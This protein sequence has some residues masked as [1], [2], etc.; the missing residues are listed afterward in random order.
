MGFL[1]TSLAAYSL[2]RRREAALRR[3]F[4]QHLAPGVVAR[5]AGAPEALK[6]SGEKR[7]VTALFTDIEGFSSLATRA[8]PEELIGLLDGYFEGVA[9]IVVEHGGMIDK[10]VGDAVHAIFN[11]PLDLPEHT[12]RAIL[13]AM[14]ILRWTESYRHQARLDNWRSVERGSGSRRGKWSW[15]TSACRPSSTIRRTVRP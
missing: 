6:L 4:E 15:A 9:G 13:C 10:F 5:I 2:A 7:R 12:D 14:A 1:V 3:R 11:A 8:S